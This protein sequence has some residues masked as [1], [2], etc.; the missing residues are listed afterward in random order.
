MALF[1]LIHFKNWDVGGEVLSREDVRSI[2][3]DA[4]FPEIGVPYENFRDLKYRALPLKDLTTL[5]DR[6]CTFGDILFRDSVYECED[7]CYR[8]HSDL[9]IGW[10]KETTTN[11]AGAL[12]AG[13]C[14]GF[15][16]DDEGKPGKHEWVW[17][18]MPGKKIVYFQG[19]TGK[20]MT[21]T[22]TGLCSAEA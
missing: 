7:F 20:I 8:M 16:V 21:W 10:A 14:S 13:I 11:A 6:Y 9:C 19:Q 3:M 5:K 1:G 4:G 22:I 15:I 2:L 17:A 18:I 12:A